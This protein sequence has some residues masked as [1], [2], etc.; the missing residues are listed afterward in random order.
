MSC[1]CANLISFT[2]FD[3]TNGFILKSQ[4]RDNTCMQISLLR[5]NKVK[6]K[7]IREAYN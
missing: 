7:K 6:E 2:H 1:C 3:M 4:P 5:E